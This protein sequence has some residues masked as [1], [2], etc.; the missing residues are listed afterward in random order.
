MTSRAGEL[1]KLVRERGLTG[2]MTLGYEIAAELERLARLDEHAAKAVVPEPP[3]SRC[4]HAS[5]DD[6]PACDHGQ[7]DFVPVKQIPSELILMKGFWESADGEIV[8][9]L[10]LCEDRHAAR[11]FRP[12]DEPWMAVLHR[13]MFDRYRRRQAEKAEALRE[14][15]A[16]ARFVE[17]GE[18]GES[19][20]PESVAQPLIVSGRAADWKAVID[21]PDI[22]MRHPPYPIHMWHRSIVLKTINLLLKVQP[23]CSLRSPT[24]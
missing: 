8:Q 9:A 4:V 7:R 1:A 21:G 13:A 17:A 2:C 16:F 10:D 6:F 5:L 22:R 24:S 20:V 19:V 15:R 3:A 11:R 23:P 18:P 14:L 12:V